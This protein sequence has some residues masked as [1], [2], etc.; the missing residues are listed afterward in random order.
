[1]SRYNQTP[2]NYSF[3][4]LFGGV[5]IGVVGFCYLIVKYFQDKHES[6]PLPTWV[7]V[8]G[9]ALTL[10]C[11]FLIPVDIYSVSSITNH[12][13]GERTL[14]DADIKQRGDVLR[15]AYYILYSGVLA[16]AFGFIPFAYF[17]Y[18]IEY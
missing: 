17:Y 7:A 10:L 14:S 1:M 18:I 3:V 8:L 11:V 2:N 9:L 12:A 5:I 13:T 16:F 6:E 15:I 4:L